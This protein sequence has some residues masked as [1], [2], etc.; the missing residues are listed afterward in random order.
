MP[1]SLKPRCNAHQKFRR[2]CPSQKLIEK[3]APSSVETLIRSR[4]IVGRQWYLESNKS[5]GRLFRQL[6]THTSTPRGKLRAVFKQLHGIRAPLQRD[7]AMNAEIE[8]C[9]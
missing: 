5:G 6:A 8:P 2:N 1:P 7:G 3:L 9:R 4:I